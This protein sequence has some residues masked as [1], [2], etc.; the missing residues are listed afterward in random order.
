MTNTATVFTRLKEFLPTGVVTFGATDSACT[1][2][3][4]EGP[5]ADDGW[6]LFPQVVVGF[7]DDSGDLEKI[8]FLV[9]HRFIAATYY[10]DASNAQLFL[11]IYVIPWD[12]PG[13]RGELRS[14]DDA[15]LKPGCKYLRQLFLKIRTERSLWE[16]SLAS[17]SN[18]AYFLGGEPDNR[19]LLDI[20]NSL[21]SPSAQPIQGD[22]P[23]LRSRLYDY[24]R[25][26]VATMVARETNPGSIEHPLYVPIQ[27]IDGKVFYMQPAT[28]E[29]LSELPRVS[30]VP[31]G[32]LCEELGTGKT[33]M[34]LSLVLA[35]L[36]QLAS[37]E[38]GIYEARHPLTPLALKLFDTSAVISERAK[39]AGR[40]KS[41]TDPDRRF[42]SLVEIMIH[43]CRVSPEGIPLHDPE[44]QEMLEQQHLWKAIRANVPFYLHS[45]PAPEGAV[46]R[47][48]RTHSSNGPKVMFLT[49]ATLIIVPDNLRRQWANEILKH[50]TDVLRVLLVDDKRELPDAPVLATDF[51]IILM[52]HSR[53]CH[54]S[55]KRN[56]ESL[57][58][59]TVCECKLKPNV[60]IRW[61]RLV[62]DEGHNTA[63]KQT[64]Y[65][66][67]TKLLSVERRWIVTGTPTTNLLG[68]NFGSGNELLYP[69]DDD[70]EKVPEKQRIWPTEER[71]D[72]RKLG[73][74][75]ADFLL[76]MPFAHDSKSFK[77]LVADPLFKPS[78]PYPGDVDVLVQV[79]STV[80]VRHRIEDVESEVRLA[81]LDNQIALL[82][83]D[84]LA[85]KTYNI[86][87][88]VIAVNAVDSEREHQDYLFHPRNSAHLQELVS[89]ISHTMFWHVSDGDH[90]ERLS[91]AQSAL[92]HLESG[93]RK[94][95]PGD[96]ELIKQ[97]IVHIQAA[98]ED[99]VW[100]SIQSQYHVFYRVENM[101]APVYDAWCTFP[102]YARKAS[103]VALLPAHVL[104]EIRQAVV[105]HPLSS[106]AKIAEIGKS[107]NELEKAYRD[108]AR[109][110]EQRKTKSSR[111]RH[112]SESKSLE[113]A[114]R[115]SAKEKMEEMQREME[116]ALARFTAKFH[117]EDGD[118]PPPVSQDDPSQHMVASS[119]LRLSPLKD[120]RIRNSLSTKLDY[121]LNEVLTYGH[122]E[123][124]LIFS[125]SPSVLSFVAEAFDLFKIKYLSFSGQHSREERQS[126]ITTFETSDLYRVLL[127]ELKH[128]AR[129]LNLVSASRVIFCEP[130]WKADVESQAIKRVHRIGQ[131]RPI[132]HVTTLAIRST[133]E[134]VM[135]T[136]SKALRENKQEVAK[137]ATDDR[138]VR[139]FLAHPTFLPV[140]AD[141]GRVNFNH[142]LFDIP[143]PP[144]LASKPAA[145]PDVHA[146]EKPSSSGSAYVEIPSGPPRK[147]QKRVA[148]AD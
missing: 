11:R 98:K 120:V 52:S 127:L 31:G 80:M 34:I 144:S 136:R 20:Y 146:A 141:E 138:T 145:A 33:I 103:P 121:I 14:R 130:V 81:L 128:G 106:I 15:V 112:A 41:K 67:F 53:F 82:D 37:P 95:L 49:S 86:M 119:L 140:P 135:V 132:V 77:T 89:N 64:D 116:A 54:E 38:E 70:A 83:M 29:I 19:T 131:T 60:L 85:V 100:V 25:R 39:L 23:G 72:L 68:L 55:K 111:D 129:G 61:K 50:C 142:P 9:R 46:G 124:F 97:A 51:D 22:I 1:S 28:M 126:I 94:G 88:A 117:G 107:F 99:P 5:L 26:S 92:Q 90:E 27:G 65:A 24:Q 35:T 2:F 118:S 96:L 59:W 133:F 36:D 84:P 139:D 3:T 13:S 113:L 45:Q 104:L 47:R 17:S 44:V 105:R 66:I 134:E 109:F 48:A 18:P 57:Y 87:Q 8:A 114:K 58:S 74:M 123:K 143:P 10:M 42:P 4:N 147:K 148:F 78:G 43:K 56:V 71:E 122:D 62:V 7:R 76:M 93:K 40:R 91:N 101:R 69:E 75:L 30:A 137:A 125:Q 21:P 63:E 79:M 12:L 102:E 16:G 110:H 115:A 6:R 73:N 108:V 32:I